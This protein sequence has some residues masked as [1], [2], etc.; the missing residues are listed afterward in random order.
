MSFPSR[1]S[2]ALHSALVKPTRGVVGLVDDL[3]V[4]CREHGLQ[5]DWHADR[6][7]AR[8]LGNGAEEWIAV[9]L[10]KSVFRAILA[11]V[12]VLCN[13]RS[14]NSVSP[15]GGQAEVSVGSTPTTVFRLTFVNTTAEQRL[16]LM[17]VGPKPESARGK[18]CD[19]NNG[20]A[21]E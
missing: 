13:E 7:R 6:C 21:G 12:A 2:D 15:Y 18:P 8:G 3:L 19:D 11:R 4:V 16:E 5:L 14:P 20:T 1:S 9:D 10:R 17:P